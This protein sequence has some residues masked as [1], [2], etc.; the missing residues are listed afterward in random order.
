[1]QLRSRAARVSGTIDRQ[2]F[3]VSWNK[4]LD[5]GGVLVGEAV[6]LDIKLELNK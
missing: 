2:D 6:A 3:G 1:V 4:S 5:N